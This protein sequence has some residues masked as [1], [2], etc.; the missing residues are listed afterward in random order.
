MNDDFNTASALGFIFELIREVNRFLDS[1]PSGQKAKDLVKQA[2]DLLAEIGSVL[3]IFNKTPDEW[4]RSLM[5]VKNIDL[6]EDDLLKKIDQREE[7][8]KNKDWST[9]DDIRNELADLNI[10]LEDKKDGTAWKIKVG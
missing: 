1:K 7:A 2:N 9:A 8:R 4:Y 3:N 10:V 6:S 5:K